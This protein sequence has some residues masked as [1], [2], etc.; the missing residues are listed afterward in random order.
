[1]AIKDIFVKDIYRSM[2]PVIKVSDQDDESTIFQELDE[3][4]VTSEI[5][6]NFEKLYKGITDGLTNNKDHM[7]VWISGDF[8]SGKSHF[9]K[10]TSFLLRNQSVSGKNSIDYLREKVSPPV[11]SMMQSVGR[12]NIDTVLFDIDA[13]SRNGQD[14]DSLVQTFMMVFNEMLGLSSNN[15]IAD[16][17][18][19]LIGLDRY[20]QFKESFKNVSKKKRSWEEERG[21]PTFIKQDIANAL[22]DCGVCSSEEDAKGIA[23]GISRESNVSVEDFAKMLGE[24][25]KSRGKDYAMFFLVDEVGQFI[26]DNVQKMLKLQTIVEELGVKA[27]GQAWVIVTSQE[28][29]EAIVSGVSNNDFSKIQGR[30]STRIKM[31]SSDVKEVIEKRVLEKRPEDSISLGAFYEASRLDINTKLELDNRMNIRL[32]RNSSEFVATYPFIPYQYDMLQ[33]MLTQLRNKSAAGKNLSNA[34]RSMLRLFKDAVAN[35]GDRDLRTVMPLYAFFDPIRDELDSPT[36]LL[37]ARARDNPALTDFDQDVL[38]TLYLV[39]YYEGLDTNIRNIS[40][41]MVDNFDVVRT[42]LMSN[43][44]ESLDR[45]VEQNFVQRVGDIYVYLTDQEQEIN[46]EI[47][48]ETFDKES[49]NKHI[50]DISFGQILSLSGTKYRFDS[51]HDYPFNK[52]VDGDNVNNTEH[53]LSLYISTPRDTTHESLLPQKSVGGVLIQLSD[54]GR[55]LEQISEYIRTDNYL[56]KK[57][58]TTLTP[59]QKEVIAARRAELPQMKARAQAALESSI[60]NARIYVNGTEVEISKDVIPDKRVNDAMKRLIESIYSKMGYFKGGKSKKD[61]ETLLKNS[62]LIPFE[63]I[64]KDC[65]KAVSDMLKYLQFNAASHSTILIKNV[66]DKFTR[67]PYGFNDSDVQWL[68]AILFRHRRIDLIHEGKTY[69]GNDV[70][71]K[72]ALDLLTTRSNMDKVKIELCESVTPEQIYRATNIYNSLFSKSIQSDEVRI[73]ETV[74]QSAKEMLKL[75]EGT[76][77]FYD[78]E[79]RYP[80]RN[81][82]MEVKTVLDELSSKQSPE[83]F[84]YTDQNEEMLRSLRDRLNNVTDFF[85]VNSQRKAL[86]D[87]G[88]S[89][90]KAFADNE[91]YLPP[92]VKDVASQIRDIIDSEYSKIPQLNILCPTLEG[93]IKSA[94]DAYRSEIKMEIEKE[95]GSIRD[96]HVDNPD[97]YDSIGRS[98]DACLSDMDSATSIAAM[99]SKKS[100]CKF[101]IE[102]SIKSVP[103]PEPAPATGSSSEPGG[104]QTP[105]PQPIPPK[106]VRQ[107]IVMRSI[108]SQ[109]RSIDSE[110]DIDEIVQELANKLKEKLA[111]GPFDIVW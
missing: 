20:E 72:R 52:M 90:L 86:F 99:N 91:D 48:R 8:G 22:L 62:S 108:A 69:R 41:L 16:F 96:E 27:R 15:S 61:I 36:N 32:Y 64:S 51:A 49:L 102:Q 73:V 53:E 29:I 10:I 9:L 97:L 63:D 5:D 24:H 111:N 47:S 14:E 59:Q 46:R 1:M 82:L 58:G 75:V 25:C 65:G 107:K 100:G 94:V 6:K 87:R 21:R 70:D 71:L 68:L 56:R 105:V 23:N 11:Y 43:I 110:D 35:Y 26:S 93:H 89:S 92:E 66:M 45:L 7:G 76:M 95:F 12:K 74:N 109:K 77:K 79:P 30:F 55:V 31:V 38:K 28:D 44:Q 13:K 78:L 60:Q 19:Y 4:V 103:M 18:R 84:K 80:G 106:P 39:K 33:V 17:E 37:F 101:L 50:A 57:D 85:A 67:K 3:Y 88:I 42:E 34:A 81:D 54:S 2:N 104:S 98:I 40:A 83:L